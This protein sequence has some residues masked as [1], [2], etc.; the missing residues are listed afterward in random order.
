MNVLNLLVELIAVNNYLV[1]L[2][3]NVVTFKQK[4]TS[5]TQQ[6][7]YTKKSLEIKYTISVITPR[8]DCP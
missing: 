4:R 1:L 8:G 3:N 2:L 7:Q 6:I 5:E